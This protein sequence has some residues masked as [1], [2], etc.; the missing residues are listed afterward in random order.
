MP[1]YRAHDCQRG[2][3]THRV[4]KPNEFHVCDYQWTK[5]GCDFMFAFA[6]AY[7]VLVKKGFHTP[8]PAVGIYPVDQDYA[9]K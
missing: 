4:L 1:I 3:E 7:P 8:I 5:E 9:A 6:I 2:W